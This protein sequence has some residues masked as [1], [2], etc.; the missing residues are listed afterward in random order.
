MR[1]RPEA[2][3]SMLAHPLR[4]RSML[5]LHGQQELCV[6]ELSHVLQAQQPVVSRHL[7]LLRQAGLVTSRRAGVWI[8]YRLDD[9]LPAWV[10]GVLDAAAAADRT[11]AADLRRLLSMKGR[12]EHGCGARATP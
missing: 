7:A 5:L 12:P 6:C 11:L 8:H 1:L 9:G 10:P 3:F 4:L 2:L